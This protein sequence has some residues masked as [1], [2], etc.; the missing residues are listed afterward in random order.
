M[1]IFLIKINDTYWFICFWLMCKTKINKL[2]KH[3]TS[4][5]TSSA[6]NMSVLFI[7]P[8]LWFCCQAN[9]K[10]PK[11]GQVF[12]YVTCNNHSRLL[13]TLWIDPLWS[14]CYNLEKFNCRGWCVV[15][16]AWCVVLSAVHKVFGWLKF[17][18]LSEWLNFP[19]ATLYAHTNKQSSIDWL[20][21]ECPTSF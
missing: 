1:L 5:Q 15:L 18:Q 8:T 14:W 13:F 17:P 19:Q 21:V 12:P 4:K 6:N 10:A 11:V 16:S 20:S 7:Q 2:F 3:W 9:S